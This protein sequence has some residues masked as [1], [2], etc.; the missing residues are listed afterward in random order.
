MAQDAI[1][2]PEALTQSKTNY[3]WVVM[4]LIFLVYTM[5]AAD[6]A[7]IGIVLPFVKNEFNMSNTE[8]GALVSLFFIGYSL[9]QIPAGFLVKRFGVS[10]VFPIFMILTSVFTGLL[11]TATSA[12]QMKIDRLALGLAE[13]PLPVAML[14]TINHWF[15]PVEKGT[16]VGMFLAAA[17]FGPVLVP[18][19]GAVIIA[20][21][22]WQYIFFFCA[23]PGL[24]FSVAWYFLVANDPAQSRFTS[25]S[26]VEHIR[27]RSPALAQ[28][29]AKP[30]DRKG[31]R[32]LRW[33]DRL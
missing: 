27:S 23:I 26:E 5:A 20:S 7:N 30:A 3:R 21:L 19:I 16:A 12:L 2:R 6:R 14:S 9:A 1:V 33:L 28:G 25:A 4:A 15:P 29:E 11:G 17:K 32:K 13:A 24:L 18:P 8:A 10:L 31:E 22:G